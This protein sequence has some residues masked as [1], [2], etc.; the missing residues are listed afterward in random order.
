[1]HQEVPPAKRILELNPEHGLIK[2]LNTLLAAGKKDQ[3]RELVALL[4]NQAVIAEGGRV[5]NP[6]DFSTRL[7]R[8]LEEHAARL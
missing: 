3:A 8:I 1:M 2:K 4:Y 5:A 7:T 6:G